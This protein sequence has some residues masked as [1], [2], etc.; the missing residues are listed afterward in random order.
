M[1]KRTVF[2][3]Y[4]VVGSFVVA[5]GCSHLQPHQ[6][7][8][9]GGE[10]TKIDTVTFIIDERS[11]VDDL[12]R[13]D[14]VEVHLIL[15]DGS[16]QKLGKT[17]T[18]GVF[19]IERQRLFGQQ[20]I[21]FSKPGFGVTAWLIDEKR[22]RLFDETVLGILKPIIPAQMPGEESNNLHRAARFEIRQ[23][24]EEPHRQI[25]S[26]YECLVRG[27][28]TDGQTGESRLFLSPGARVWVI[29]KNGALEQI[30]TT[31]AHGRILISAEIL[32]DSVFLGASAE[33]DFDGGWLIEETEL[34]KY[35][36]INL[37]LARFLVH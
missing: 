16:V 17:S 21:L 30:G 6:N 34:A 35:R 13:S 15:G 14:D 23:L 8:K 32:H 7:I 5:S 36:Q 28:G 27:L 18:F 22:L 26:F 37:S 31:D 24:L 19:H 11:T 2:L 20:A 4:L 3:V 9:P 25:P 10:R 29:R 12:R 33:W 1:R